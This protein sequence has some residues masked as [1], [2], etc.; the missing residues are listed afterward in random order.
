LLSRA[1]LSLAPRFVLRLALFSF[2]DFA[3]RLVHLSLVFDSAQS[4]ACITVG[5]VL[6]PLGVAP[7][8]S[9][10]GRWD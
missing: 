4:V 5:F 7:R 1:V 3:L 10:V 2:L 8:R 9:G 6:E